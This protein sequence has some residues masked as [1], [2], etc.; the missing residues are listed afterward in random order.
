MI[1]KTEYR[2][3]DALGLSALIRDGQVEAGEVLETAIACAESADPAVHA[4]SQK[5]YDHGRE[6]LRVGTGEGPFAGVPFLLKDIGA[7]L[8]GTVTTNGS[9]FYADQPPA[10]A[11]STLTARYKQAGLVIFGKTTTPEMALAASTEGSFTGTT[12]NP[13]AL[14]RTSG[15]SSG[16]A[17]AA[18]ASGIVPAAHASD[19]GG[20][21]R[22]PASC[23][24][25]FGLKPTRARTPAGPYAGEGWGS[26]SVNHVL[27][28]SVRDSAALLDATQG[29]APG[30]PYCAP[31]VE[32]P[33]LSE[34]GQPPGRL[35]IGLQR[36][37]ISGVPVDPECARA[38]EKAAHLLATL[39]HDVE[40]AQPPGDWE[41][42]G[43]ALWALVAS[44]VSVTLKKRAAQLGRPLSENDVDPVTWNAVAH[45]ATLDADA[46][47]AAISVI[48]M[49]G[50]RMAEF[51]ETYDVILSPTLAK[52]P[53][54]LGPQRTDNPDLEAYGRA[55][56]EFSPFTQL[57][58]MTG[59][60]SMSVPLHWSPDNLPIGVMF[61]A[62]FGEEALLIRLASQLEQAK[63]W[64]DKIAIMNR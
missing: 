9:C 61:S 58:N 23:C 11:D 39:G 35:R 24:G 60:P 62:R 55:L 30:D 37:P 20:S 64:F 59:Q 27:T 34:V 46:Y 2:E 28:R 40:D 3:H 29:Y 14:D 36:H 42:L 22:I 17:A 44:N 6:A 41:E 1:G 38:A 7:T 12:R 47:P 53:V 16:G 8:R 51:H 5:L 45:A 43:S 21:I 33:F 4:L 49:Q 57:F 13:W 63:P 31:A 48:H 25:L 32:R 26:L 52:P 10:Q 18:V 19:G 15:G 50:R 54:P 56:A